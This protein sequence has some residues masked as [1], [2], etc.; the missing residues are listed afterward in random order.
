[1]NKVAG[2]DDASRLADTQG[3]KTTVD[4]VTGGA[5]KSVEDEAGE[6]VGGPFKDDPLGQSK[7]G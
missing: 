5:P 1:M 3:Y 4:M 6:Q 2:Q 7:S